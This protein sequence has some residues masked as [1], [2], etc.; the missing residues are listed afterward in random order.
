M[1]RIKKDVNLKELEKFGFEK[2]EWDIGSNKK[3]VKYIKNVRSEFVM[4]CKPYWIKESDVYSEITITQDG[5][6]T[7][8]TVIPV[9]E[10]DTLY[11]LIQARISRESRGII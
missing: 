9:L 3:R 5:D 1:L 10:L 4:K 8:Q 7:L 6:I 11:D 2:V